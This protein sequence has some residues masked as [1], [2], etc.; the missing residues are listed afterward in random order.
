MFILDISDR[1]NRSRFAAVT[2][3]RRTAACTH[4]VMQ[5]FERELLIVTDEARGRQSGSG[6]WTVAR[7]RTSCRS[8][9]GIWRIA[10]SGTPTG[11]IIGTFVVYAVHRHIIQEIRF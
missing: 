8:R 10:P 2:T 1:S 7:R 11:I 9:R 5:L 6:S 4:T 3:R